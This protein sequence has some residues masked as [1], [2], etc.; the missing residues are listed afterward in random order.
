MHIV[1]SSRW[2]FFYFLWGNVVWFFVMMWCSFG[3]NWDILIVVSIINSSNDFDVF[4]IINLKTCVFHT[5][6]SCHVSRHSVVFC[7]NLL[8][9]TFFAI[10]LNVLSLITNSYFFV[11]AIL[12]FVLLLINVILINFLENIT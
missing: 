12:I 11:L 6:L 9:R 1:Y 4:N 10:N 2:I 8:F 7:F 3:S 5:L